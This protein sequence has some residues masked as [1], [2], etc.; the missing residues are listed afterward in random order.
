ML[1]V[2]RHGQTDWNVAGKVQGKT[3]I[4]LNENGLNQANVV[5]EMLKDV[6]F[7]KVFSSPLSRAKRTAEIICDSKSSVLT[8]ERIS[9]R[10]MGNFEGV[11]PHSLD[12]D[13][14]WD[15]SK[16]TN[17]ENVEPVKDLI[18][19]VH[20]FLD[21]NKKSYEDGDALLVT[22]GGVF[23]A[24][25]AY[26]NGIPSDKQVLTQRIKNCEVVKFEGNKNMS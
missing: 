24:V 5:K 14:L 9:E 15:Y 25:L 18:N 13:F 19:R 12:L 17:V 11:D 26:F 2:V 21:E 16:N 3:D 7:T 22:H 8:D 6:S 4:P 23:P 1:Y 10:C 20:N